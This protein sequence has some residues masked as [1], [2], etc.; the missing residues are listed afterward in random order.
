MP[1]T[2]TLALMD[3]LYRDSVDGTTE[4]YQMVLERLRPED[5]VLDL[6]CGFG[7]KETDV[8]SSA[9]M[10]VGCDI[11]DDLKE[12]RFVSE[13][14]LGSAYQ[15]PF[16]TAS[17]DAVLMDYVLEH[18]ESPA[19]CAAEIFRVLKPGGKLLFRTPNLFHYVALISHATPFSFH[20]KAVR[21]I[22]KSPDINPFATYYRVNTKK[23]VK[24]CFESAGFVADEIRM[25]EKEPSYLVFARPALL[26]GYGYE[27]LVN[28]SDRFAQLRSNIF[29]FFRKPAA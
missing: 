24:R 13:K 20:R 19:T 1:E 12:N 14:A 17:F 4:F 29:G 28:M 23:A 8:R 11:G 6:G 22:Q 27:R 5:R 9:R 7:R 26:L 16:Q 2:K 10:V 3:Q 25:V 15:L 21:W 18:I